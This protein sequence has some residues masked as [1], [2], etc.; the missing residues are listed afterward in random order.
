M[1][2]N[3]ELG[4]GLERL[5]LVVVLPILIVLVAAS[6]TYETAPEAPTQFRATTVIR[7]PT[8]VQDSAAAVN[9][10]IADLDELITGDATVDHVVSQVPGLDR[11]T[12]VDRITASRRGTTSSV[13]LSFVHADQAVAANTVGTLARRLLDDAARGEYE[14]T[15]F[16]LGRAT[17]RLDQAEA[18]I[19]LFFRGVS[20]FDP[21]FE[22]RSVL[23]EIAQLDEQITTG[24]AL[25]YGE[26]Y[27]TE[28]AARRAELQAMLPELGSAMLIHERLS[29]ELETAQAAWEEATINNDLEE[30]EYRTVNSLDALITS[31]EVGPFVD[32][33]PRLQRTALAAA[34]ALVLSLVVILP[35][36]VWLSRPRGRHKASTNGANA[37]TVDLNAMSRED[38]NHDG[39]PD[40]DIENSTVDEARVGKRRRRALGPRP[41]ATGRAPGRPP[42]EK[43]S[44]V[45][46]EEQQLELFHGP[47]RV[48]R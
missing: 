32:A 23:N 14:R 42:V 16:L 27:Q 8:T 28:L 47:D 38:S 1:S 31:E 29:T 37:R 3:N 41:K 39:A 34:L 45:L 5:G 18:E 40:I 33:T 43:P 9:L 10:F 21:E 4:G 48:R 24:L 19:E 13:A 12:Y 6:A 35:F 25:S 15:Q 36:S 2:E 46:S 30:F 44:D 7:P 26:T 22:Y 20:V 17:E 11:E